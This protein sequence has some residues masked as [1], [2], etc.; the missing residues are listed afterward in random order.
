MYREPCPSFKR[1]LMQ[2]FKLHCPRRWRGHYTL[3]FYVRLFY[4]MGKALLFK[5]SCTGQ[6]LVKK[7][8]NLTVFTTPVG[9]CENSF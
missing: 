7:G 8:D 5:L 9:D 1:T 4:V 6:G 2:N 3:K